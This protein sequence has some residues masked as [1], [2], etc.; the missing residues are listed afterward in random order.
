MCSAQKNGLIPGRLLQPALQAE[1]VRQCPAAAAAPAA[2]CPAA[3]AAA[4]GP[5]EGRMLTRLGEGHVNIVRP[6]EIV[7]TSR[8]LAF[9]QEYVPGEESSKSQPA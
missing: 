8:H 9:V 1:Y 7:L 4:A 2:P 5:R 6:L 3:A